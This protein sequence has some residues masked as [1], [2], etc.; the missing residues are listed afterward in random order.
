MDTEVKPSILRA[1]ADLE[2]EMKMAQRIPEAEAIREALGVLTRASRGWLSTGQ[3]AER[4]GISIPTVK[5][6]IK[7]GTLVG[8][9]VGGRWRVSSASVDKVLEVRQVLTEAEAEGYPSEAEIQELT[10]RVR[11]QM[12]AEKARMSG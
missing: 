2:R 3:A 12:S 1:L 4:L 5:D 8:Q 10:T 9:L 11:R 6:W 7:R